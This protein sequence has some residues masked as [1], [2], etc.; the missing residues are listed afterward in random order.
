MVNDAG[1]DAD[2]NEQEP[3]RRR[4][5][6]RRILR[7]TAGSLVAV[8]LVIQLIPYGRD[9]TNP[10]ITEA[11][12]W[13]SPRTEELVQQSCNDCHSNETVWPWYSNIAPISWLVQHDVDE[14]RHK[15]N[16]SEWDRPGQEIDESAETIREGEMPVWYY[17]ITHRDASLSEAEKQE[18]IDGFL[19]TFGS[20]SMHEG[21]N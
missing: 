8:L 2:M 11:V 17:T 15:L 7:W 4:V 16:F 12:V 19:A 21:D 13:D 5:N 3:L 6:W 9:H 18:L 20:G 14:G 10:P 1:M